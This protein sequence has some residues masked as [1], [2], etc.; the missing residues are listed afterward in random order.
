MMNIT[1]ETLCF[2]AWQLCYKYSELPNTKHTKVK[3]TVFIL[4]CYFTYGFAC[5]ISALFYFCF[6]GREHCFSMQVVM[7]N[8]LLLT[9]KKWCK[10]VLLFSRNTQKTHL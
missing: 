10:F 2:S 3:F 4:L 8:F 9:L 1:N 7:N 6:K 5:R